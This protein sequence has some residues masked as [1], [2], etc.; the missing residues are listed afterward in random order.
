MAI[1]ADVAFL[2]YRPGQGPLKN[3]REAEKF[4][5]VANESDHTTNDDRSYGITPSPASATATA[6]PLTRKASS[7][8]QG[9]IMPQEIAQ[10]TP[11]SDAAT[12]YSLKQQQQQQ[13]HTDDLHYRQQNLTQPRPVIA[14]EHAKSNTSEK[15]T[16]EIEP[17][18]AGKTV[19]DRCTPKISQSSTCNN[20]KLIDFRRI[21]GS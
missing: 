11:S 8:A 4:S 6:P 19:P 3:R 9:G 5:P 1:E 14:L 15:L 7:I 12:A 13:H 20:F 16:R 10:T 21:R 17:Y 2:R 18:F